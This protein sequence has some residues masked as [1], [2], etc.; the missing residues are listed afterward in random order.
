VPRAST[1][2]VHAKPASEEIRGAGAAPQVTAGPA[3]PSVRPRAGDPAPD[4][5]TRRRASASCSPS[6]RA[7]GITCGAGHSQC[8]GQRWTAWDGVGCLHSEQDVR[9]PSRTAGKDVPARPSRCGHE[10]GHR[11]GDLAASLAA[12]L[13]MTPNA[14]HELAPARVEDQDR[15]ERRARQ[16]TKLE[17]R[18]GSRLAATAGSN[19]LD[20]DERRS[21][22][23]L[24]SSQK[25]EQTVDGSSPRRNRT[26][27]VEGS[28]P[29]SSIAE[30][31]LRV[32]G[33]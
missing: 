6:S 10:P 21:G 30:E 3:Q 2:E 20:P 31:A 26:Q 13:A 32:S 12:S 4:G 33:R 24:H 18:Y 22:E 1:S 19:S 28:S 14:V 23:V 8:C 5:C 17:A 15:G 27:E 25:A 16:R 9:E 7:V 11:Y 29:P